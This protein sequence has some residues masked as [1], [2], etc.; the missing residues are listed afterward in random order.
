GVL[1]QQA[2]TAKSQG[3]IGTGRHSQIRQ[4]L[5]TADVQQTN[6]NAAISQRSDQ[7]FQL[8]FEILLP[9]PTPSAE[10]ELFDPQEPAPVRAIVECEFHIIGNPNVRLHIDPLP[11][12][13]VRRLMTGHLAAYECRSPVGYALLKFPPR[14]FLRRDD[15]SASEAVHQDFPTTV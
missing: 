10:V 6:R 4:R 1:E 3:G 12:Q 9:R 8:A 13:G 7:A 2:D 15:E 5:V 11:V 14:V